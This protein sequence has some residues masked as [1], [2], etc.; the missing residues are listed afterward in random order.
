MRP[1]INKNLV[2]TTSESKTKK[3]FA[4]KNASRNIIFVMTTFGK[5]KEIS[6]KDYLRLKNAGIEVDMIEK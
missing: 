1:R 3:N 6:Y 4:K 2:S 5:Q